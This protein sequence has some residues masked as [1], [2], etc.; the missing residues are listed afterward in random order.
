MKIISRKRWGAKGTRGDT[1][2]YS[3]ATKVYIHHSATLK[4]GIDTYAEQKATIKEFERHH[5][6]QGWDGIGYNY[7]VFPAFKRRLWHH[8]RVFE[9]RGLG[10]IP[11][12]QRGDNAHNVAICVVGNFE[13]EQI[14]ARTLGVL[15]QLINQCP[16]HFLRGH[17]DA[18]GT[19]CPGKHLYSRLGELR[20]RTHRQ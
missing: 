1:T 11:A 16:G 20:E 9:G 10:H 18:G 4:A 14:D 3:H 8:A 6:S 2:T 15:V 13:V 12:A 5:L 7:V 19:S 17:R